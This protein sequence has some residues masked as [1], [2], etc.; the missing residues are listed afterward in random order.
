MGQVIGIVFVAVLVVVI[1]YVLVQNKRTTEF[2][3]LNDVIVK[4]NSQLA[5]SS[6]YD[7]LV[8]FDKLSALADSEEARLLEIKDETLLAK[9][10]SVIPG[11]LQ[12]IANTGAVKDYSEAT[13][14]LY[15]VI[16]PKDAVLDKSR[17]LKNAFR[18]T[19]RDKL[20]RIN[21]HANLVV[22]DN[23][24][25]NKMAAMNVANTAMGVAAMV[26]GQYYMTQINDQL[27]GIAGGIE[28]LV[29]FQQN[30]FK[31]KVYA[32]V[33]EVQRSSTFQIEN[34][35]N[36]MLRSREL[37]HLKGLEHECAQ[38]L[39]QVNLSLQDVSGN[40]GVKYDKYEKL[41]GEAE[42]WYQYQQIL[43]EIMNNISALTYALNL[44]AISRAQ[45]YALYL[46]YVKQSETVLVKLGKWHKE[47]VERLGIS[48]DNNRRK[49]Q[50][51]ERIFMGVLGLFNDDNNYKKMSQKT[52]AMILH[53]DEGSINSLAVQ[54]D[55]FRDD[56][57]LVA[58]DG[59][60]YYL[61]AESN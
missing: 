2:S 3:T 60:L 40:K 22:A 30:E 17:E 11:T 12:T 56:V 27:K 57:R 6:S 45:S 33:A 59:K 46:P 32:L 24:A 58:K 7:M 54:D 1:A 44:G 47:N 55:L 42:C 35:E 51:V 52:V 43:L 41:I 29:D 14:Q 8:S 61:P 31:S 18:A 53:Q 10:A 48:L 25:A 4:S 23:S 39:G 13:R 38:L 26:V 21:G 16:I 15:Q 50:G 36:N 20:G 5:E 28:K 19:Y 37:Q 9:I 49:R 34:V